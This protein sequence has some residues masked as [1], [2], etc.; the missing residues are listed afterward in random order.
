MSLS[1]KYVVGWCFNMPA[2][3]LFSWQVT[4]LNALKE[5]FKRLLKFG[6]RADVKI[7][8]NV[9]QRTKTAQFNKIGFE[10]TELRNWHERHS[11]GSSFEKG[12]HYSLFLCWFLTSVYILWKSAEVSS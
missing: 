7:Y 5:L 4:S 6:F 11:S 10:D 1:D 12:K 2:S 3:W 8:S 9:P